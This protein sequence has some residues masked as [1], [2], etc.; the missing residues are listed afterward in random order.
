MNIDSTIHIKCELLA[1]VQDAAAQMGLSR[2]KV[3]ILLMRHVSEKKELEINMFHRIHYQLRDGEPGRRIHVWLPP[4]VYETFQDLRKIHK[5]SISAIIAFAIHEYLE[6]L[7]KESTSPEE[8]V[9]ADN[10][11]HNY[12]FTARESGGI[13]KFVIY[14][15]FPEETQLEEYF[16]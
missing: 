2:S 14:W 6:I 5:M 1:K 4:E 11:H 13:Q 10:Y 15:G 8:M 9:N 16:T 12:L 7:L 3:I